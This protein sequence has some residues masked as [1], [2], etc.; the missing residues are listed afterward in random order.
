MLREVQITQDSPGDGDE[1]LE[2]LLHALWFIM[3]TLH[4]VWFIR[5]V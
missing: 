3:A 2:E 5:D 1:T 4:T